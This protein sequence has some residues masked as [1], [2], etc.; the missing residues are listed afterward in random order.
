MRFTLLVVALPFFFVSAQA[1]DW[2]YSLNGETELTGLHWQNSVGPD[3]KKNRGIINQKLPM[4]VKYG[5]QWRFRLLPIAQYD[6]SNVS[7]SERFFWDVQEGYLQ[8]QSLPWT[9]QVGMNVFSWGDTD[10]FNPLDVV[11]QR[12]YFDPMQ[13]E[14]LGAPTVLVKREF[15]KFFIEAL[16]IPKQRKTLLPGEKSRWLPRDVY[17]SRSFSVLGY[18][19]I[20][21]LPASGVNYRYQA[22]EE[23]DNALDNN[24]GTRIKFRFPGFDWTLAGFQGTAPTPAVKPTEVGL[25]TVQQ[26]LSPTDAI[27]NMEEPNLTLKA[28]YYKARMLGTSGTLVAGDF[29]I[30][31]AS[32]YNAP[33]K[34]ASDLPA[35]SLDNAL[36]IERTFSVGKGTLTAIIQG[37]YVKRGDRVDTNSVSLARMFDRAGMAAFRWSPTESI[38]VLGS[39]LRDTRYKG[40][41]VHS[42]ASYKIAD[43]WRGKVS[44]DFLSGPT[45]TPIGTYARN[46][47]VTLSLNS[48]W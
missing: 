13:S 22:P 14:K 1:A 26:I 46:D 45:E 8:F 42:E 10:V 25:L 47:R 41:L 7:K 33:V 5:R 38:A 35:K 36:G 34:P 6:P 12:R 3:T 37:T 29:L 17:N 31:G 16:Y 27:F 48:Q 23:R 30:K 11:N 20:L 39:Y 43:G 32:A 24:F 18:H 4:A 40:T 9:F 21:N 28:V 2:K 19:A 44:A 15:E